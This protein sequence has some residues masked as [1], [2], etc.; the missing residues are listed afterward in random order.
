MALANPP[1]PEG[2]KARDLF[3]AAVA[4]FADRGYHATSTRDIA[5]RA[6]LSPAGMYVHYRSKDELLAAICRSGHGR[7]HELM[8]AA[9]KLRDPAERLATMA[10]DSAV[11][12]AE[13][14][15][16]ARVNQNEYRALSDGP[17]AEIVALRRQITALHLTA[18]RAGVRKGVF[19]VA[20]VDGTSVALLTMCHDVARWFP[21]RAVDDPQRVGD[22]Y[23]ALALRM[24]GAS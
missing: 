12:H 16:L 23:A 18:M 3:D 1:D 14:H 11:F 19:R 22:L 5:S 8:A 2:S 24:V 20:D 21:T 17:R 9:A 10:R 6:G 7:V 13:H 15:T 4:A